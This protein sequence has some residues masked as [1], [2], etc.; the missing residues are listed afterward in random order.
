MGDFVPFAMMF[1]PPVCGIRIMVKGCGLFCSTVCAVVALVR[2]S[3]RTPQGRH[4]VTCVAAK[5][6][7]NEIITIMV[8]SLNEFIS[9]SSSGCVCVGNTTEH[10][11]GYS[12][13]TLSF[14]QWDKLGKSEGWRE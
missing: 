11:F 3:S 7:E 12:L 5:A 2:N 4:A 6:R 10:H 8:R 1:I 13:H 9:C 14:A